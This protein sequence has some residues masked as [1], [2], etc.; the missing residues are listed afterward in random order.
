MGKSERKS[1]HDYERKIARWMRALGV[2]AERNVTETQQGNTG[3][4]IGEL[5]SWSPNGNGT[6]P[7]PRVVVQAK[8]QKNPSVWAAQSEADAA[9]VSP[10]DIAISFVRR[11]GDATLV[12]MRADIFGALFRLAQLRLAEKSEGS[13]EKVLA[14]VRELD[15]R[16]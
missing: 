11:K 13:W 10:S 1:G 7:G 12:L 6:G 5:K 4:V 3:D 9:T 15:G 16:P 8:F 14:R 2:T